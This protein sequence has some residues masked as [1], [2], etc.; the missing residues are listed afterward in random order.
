MI[1]L[2]CPYSHPDPAVRQARFE[3]ANRAAGAMMRD[4]LYVYSPISHTHPIAMVC[5]LPLGWDYWEGYDR[6]ML[7][8]CSELVV[9]MLAGWQESVGVQGEMQI[10]EELGLPVRFIEPCPPHHWMISCTETGD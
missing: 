7:A 9:L 4:G 6:A 10:A 3:A 2:A 1:Y 8:A 5:D